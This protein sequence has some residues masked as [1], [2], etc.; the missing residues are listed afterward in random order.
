MRVL[1]C[2]YVEGFADLVTVRVELHLVARAGR[3][4]RHP[5]PAAKMRATRMM[6]TV[7]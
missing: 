5:A 7:G 3:H 6:Y 4:L 1:R 2:E